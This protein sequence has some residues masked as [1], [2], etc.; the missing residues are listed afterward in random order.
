MKRTER[1]DRMQS[2]S[3]RKA[4]RNQLKVGANDTASRSAG[5]AAAVPCKED[6]VGRYS[7]L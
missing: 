7:L 6:G 3:G 4:E 5:A 1:F 2:T